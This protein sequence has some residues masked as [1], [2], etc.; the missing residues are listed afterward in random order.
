MFK[1][2]RI[3]LLM[4]KKYKIGDRI[5]LHDLYDLVISKKILP[6]SDDVRK[7]VR[8]VLSHLKKN[9]VLE[10]VGPCEYVVMDPNRILGHARLK[11]VISSYA[12][13]QEI[14]Q[15]IFR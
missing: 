15:I 11:D 3:K 10:H 9:G 14:N 6:E 5:K 1:A 13:W 2:S 4:A 8:G 7:D 12:I